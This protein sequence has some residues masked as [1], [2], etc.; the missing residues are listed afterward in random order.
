MLA[1][2]EIPLPNF[3]NHLFVFQSLHVEVGG[4]TQV[5]LPRVIVVKH[6]KTGLHFVTNIQQEKNYLKNDRK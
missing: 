4:K 5:E 3:V 6:A 2:T 1:V